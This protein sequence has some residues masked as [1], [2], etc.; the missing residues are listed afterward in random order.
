MQK[1]LIIADDLTGANDTGVQFVNKGVPVL[2][3]TGKT[4]DLRQHVKEFQV[5]VVN[6]E[7]RHLLSG[8]AAEKVRT[9]TEAALAAGV[10]HFY[11]KTDSTLR[12]NIGS[13]LEA[14]MDALRCKILPFVPAFPKLRR[15]THDGYHYVDGK[16]L[17][18]TI[19]A[20]DPLE[21]IKE[22]YV[23]SILKRQTSVR[24]KS[25]SRAAIQLRSRVKVFDEAG[26]YVLDAST[27]GD[28]SE[29]GEFLR[30][31]NQLK[32]VAGSAGFAACLPNL[33]E[34]ERRPTTWKSPGGNMLVISGSVNE[35]SL[36]QLSQ[37]EAAGFAAMTLPPEV[38]VSE[39]GSRS[40]AARAE[41]DKIVALNAQ[42]K[43][44][45][46]RS[47]E[48][49]E[50]LEKCVQLGRRKGIEAKQLHLRIAENLGQIGGQVLKS[51]DFK[52]I[53]VFGGDTLIE[54]ARSLNWF[55]LLPQHEIMPGITVSKV[56]ES[57]GDWLLITKAGGFGQENALIQI[58]D[59]LRSMN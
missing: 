21:P 11:K 52:L 42:R 51:T 56:A 57:E 55:G 38:L 18:Q 58:R 53:T 36:R 45:I 46:L 9:V 44:V 34:W 10:S 30:R 2:V 50:D 16:L 13:E 54:I 39:S 4:D 31:E 17:H 26:I 48:K 14:L 35:V 6:T 24:T 47:I 29:I 37:A 5:L 22:S 12:G 40:T 25:L 23:P 3:L 33:F 19:F 15:T 7:S 20:K 27:D 41:I 43:D 28:L 49:A 59:L 32:A 1:L 8:E